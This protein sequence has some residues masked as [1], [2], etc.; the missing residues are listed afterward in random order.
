MFDLT[1]LQD[2]LSDEISPAYRAQ[3]DL[4][5]PFYTKIEKAFNWQFVDDLWTAQSRLSTIEVEET[6]VR[7]LRLGA[8]LT[9]A[10]LMK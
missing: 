4:L 6:F 2:L 1:S 7:G 10:L 3:L 8:Q 5:D 9:L